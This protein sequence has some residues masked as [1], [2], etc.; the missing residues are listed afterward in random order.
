MNTRKCRKD[1]QICLWSIPFSIEEKDTVLTAA[2]IIG[3]RKPNFYHAAIISYAKKIIAKHEASLSRRDNSS[4][5]GDSSCRRVRSNRGYRV[6]DRRSSHRPSVP[7]RAV[8]QSVAVAFISAGLRPRFF[9]RMRL[10]ANTIQLL[11]CCLMR[12]KLPT[13]SVSVNFL[14][15]PNSSE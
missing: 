2:R 14:I 1:K 3:L 11:F 5:R 10:Q 12:A 13:I 8:V 4:D 7:C 9:L 15:L 6:D